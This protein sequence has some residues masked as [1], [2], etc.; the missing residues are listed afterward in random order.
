MV[1]F[2]QNKSTYINDLNAGS[3]IA[4]WGFRACARGAETCSAV[5][6][7]FENAF[8]NRAEATLNHLTVFAQIL[9]SM[10]RRKILLSPEG[11][12]KISYDEL[13]LIATFAAAQSQNSFSLDAHL[14][15]LLGYSPSLNAMNATMDIGD[16][17]TKGGFTLAIPTIVVRAHIPFS[18]QATL[19]VHQGGRA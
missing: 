3:G 10:G 2:A 18:Q 14:S 17:F 19:K 12:A 11:S 13:S 5:R 6:S 16:A 15:W 8:G 9:C 1:F 4:I 7:S